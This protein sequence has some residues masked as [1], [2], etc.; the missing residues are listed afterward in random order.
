MKNQGIGFIPSKCGDSNTGPKPGQTRLPLQNKGF[1][2]L[3]GK[4]KGE[5]CPSCPR[6][7]RLEQEELGGPN[8]LRGWERI[9]S[10]FPIRRE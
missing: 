9:R 10:S 6:R 4:M 8:L 2:I 3:K 7:H 5:K 1:R